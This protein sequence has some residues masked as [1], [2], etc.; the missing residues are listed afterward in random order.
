M[1]WAMSYIMECT[2]TQIVLGSIT[3]IGV[4]L[5]W[6]IKSAHCLGDDEQLYVQGYFHVQVFKGPGV[7]LLLPF[8]Y[9]QYLKRKAITL[10]AMN[11]VK[12]KNILTGDEWVESGPRLLFLGPYDVADKI[13]EGVSLSD[14]E[15]VLVQNDVTGAKE[16]VKGPCTW[17]PRTPTESCSLKKQALTLSNREC[18]HI[19]DERTGKKTIQIG[20]RLWF[21]EPHEVGKKISCVTVYNGEYV[22]IQDKSNGSVRVEKGP[23]LWFADPQE[24][25]EKHRGISLTSTQYLVVKDDSTGQ[26]S[27]VKGPQIWFPE[28]Y[29]T[30]VGEKRTAHT[31]QNDEFAKITDLATGMSWVMR[32]EAQLFLEPT[33]VCESIGKIYVLQPNEYV[34]LLNKLTGDVVRHC[35]EAGKAIV[36]V[37]EA[38]QEP[39]DG[40]KQCA[41]DLKINEYV[42]ILDQST[43]EVRVQRGPD[44]VFLLSHEKILGDKRRAV[45]L[46]GTRAVLLFN[47]DTGMTRIEWMN[48]LCFVPEAYESIV[49]VRPICALLDHEAVVVKDRDGI[50][51]YH[52][53]GKGVNSNPRSFFL[54]PHAEIVKIFWSRGRHRI[55][56]DLCISRFECRPQYMSFNFKCRTED[57]VELILEGAMFWQIDDLT[58]LLNTT[59]DASGDICTRTRSQ[60]IKSIST[61][62]LKDF[63]ENLTLVSD[64]VLN[65]DP[66]FYT[67]RGVKIHFLAVET[68][69]CVDPSTSRILESIINETTRRMNCKLQQKSENDVKLKKIHGDIE[70]GK[71]GR[72]LFD[73][74]REQKLDAAKTLGMANATS[75]SAF[76]SG[77]KGQV[78]EPTMCL[79][80]WR[81]FRDNEAYAMLAE[82]EGGTSVH[83]AP[84]NVKLDIKHRK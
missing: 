43:G 65:A 66:D 6:I 50:F 42:K 76:L 36:V 58:K 8:T 9:R 55:K 71:L 64:E 24:I 53:G 25:G 32:G 67:E 23:K 78:P 57:H 77:V 70:L 48:Q 27:T 16:V 45:D 68:F 49:E 39:L 31:L 4:M 35:G 20:P 80:M 19:T 22:R 47:N 59:S 30:A 5:L 52:Y 34:R 18:V 74:E 37:C 63:M 46:D 14:C 26:L 17:F 2:Q 82:T 62:K 3:L 81:T 61:R 40:G 73:A 29:Q 21:P 12:L 1:F 13:S 75:I 72:E 28:P 10:G 84:S 51:H 56:K 15:F 11:Y 33:W 41:L 79:E 83:Y 7:K 69:E 38:D 44:P 60:F 54:E